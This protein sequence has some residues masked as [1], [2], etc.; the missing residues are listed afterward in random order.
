MTTQV[1]QTAAQVP[2]TA[3]QVPQTAAQVP[4][5][6]AQCDGGNVSADPLCSEVLQTMFSDDLNL[7]HC[8][9][10]VF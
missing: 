3:A 6:A 1:P 8:V 4:Q 9:S 2:Q 5:T 7:K 10:A